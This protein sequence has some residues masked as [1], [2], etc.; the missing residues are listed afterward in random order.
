[1]SSFQFELYVF[2]LVVVM[3][4]IPAILMNLGF[5]APLQ[6]YELA[7]LIV[8]SFSMAF[9][10]TFILWRAYKSFGVSRK[11]STEPKNL[12]EKEIDAHRTQT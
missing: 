3:A 7:G 1:M 9:L 10:S 4:E 8:H 5:L 11:K 6:R 12:P 2:V